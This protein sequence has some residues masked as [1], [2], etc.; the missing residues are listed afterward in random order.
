MTVTP[1]LADQLEA[2]GVAERLDAFGEEFR[3]AS[4]MPA[5]AE[6][7]NGEFRAPCLD[8]ADRYR[9]GLARLEAAGGP[10]GAFQEAEREGRVSLMTSSATHAVLPL[11]AT[12]SA[13]NLQLDAGLRSHRRRF[14]E[15]DGIWL[16]ECAYDAGARGPG[17]SPWLHPLLRRPVG[18]RGAARRASPDRDRGRARRLSDRLGGSVVAL[19]ARRLSVGS[20]PHR[21]SPRVLARRAGVV[22][23]GR[24]PRS[25]GRGQGACARAGA[26]VRLAA[27]SSAWRATA[28]DTA[29]RDLC[30]FAIDTELLGHWWWEGPEW[31]AEVVSV[32]RGQRGR[33]RH[34]GGRAGAGRARGG[35]PACALELGR[36]QGSLDLGLA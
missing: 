24:D 20:G 12:D 21:L 3:L 36:A 6:E 15:P 32:G 8:E 10:L 9:R 5:D 28:S 22:D 23:R 30:V 19:V 34:A 11:L 4:S 29:R 2:P 7:Q 17:R 1:V 35:S 13:R 25:R 27:I 26:R 14:G 16:P 18:S 33:A 31:L